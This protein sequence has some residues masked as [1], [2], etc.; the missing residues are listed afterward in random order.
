MWAV[1]HGENYL[2][3]FSFFLFFFLRTVSLVKLTWPKKRNFYIQS[4]MKLG[5]ND[6]VT[7]AP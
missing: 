3:V 6:A 5:Y 4:V 7:A 1:F 2:Y